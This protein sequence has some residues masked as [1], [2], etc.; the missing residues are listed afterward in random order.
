MKQIIAIGLVIL[1]VIGVVRLFQGSES[2]IEQTSRQ[3]VE[4]PIPSLDSVSIS[5]SNNRDYIHTTS[6]LVSQLTRRE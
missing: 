2:K 1:M 4:S 6:V 5:P 3:Q